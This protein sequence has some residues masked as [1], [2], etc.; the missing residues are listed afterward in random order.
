MCTEDTGACAGA[1]VNIVVSIASMLSNFIPGYGQLK[2]LGQRW[3]DRALR[4]QWQL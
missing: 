3:P 1:I 2:Q 4:L